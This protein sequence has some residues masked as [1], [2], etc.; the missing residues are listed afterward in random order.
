MIGPEATKSAAST[1]NRKKEALMIARESTATEIRIIQ[2]S[3]DSTETLLD[4]LVREAKEYAIFQVDP[5]G[6]ILNW[7]LGAE[8]MKQFTAEEAIGQNYRMLYRDED[9][10]SG[11]PERN[12]ALAIELGRHEEQWW[13]RKKDGTLFWADAVMTPIYSSD[14]ELLTFSKIVRDLTEGKRTE[15]ALRAA[16][17]AVEAASGLKSTFIAHMNHEIRTPLGAILG[18][19]EVLKDPAC[20]PKDRLISADVIDRNGK[21]LLRLIEDV[22]DISKIET[23]KLDIEISQFSLKILLHEIVDYFKTRASAKGLLLKIKNNNNIPDKITSDPARLRQILCNIIGNSVKFT[24]KGEVTIDV[25]RIDL[26]EGLTGIEF[27]VADTGAGLNGEERKALFKPFAQADSAINR[28][29]GGTGLGLALSRRLAEKLGGDLALSDFI[30][31]GGCSFRITIA[32]MDA[33]YLKEA[34]GA[35]SIAL[36]KKASSCNNSTVAGTKILVVDD[37]ADNRLLLKMLLDKRGVI[38]EFSKNGVEAVEKASLFNY[39]LIL[40]DIQMPIMDGNEAMR[41]LRRSGYTFPIVAV[42]AHS[43][44]EEKAKS[45][46][47]GCDDFLIKPINTKRLFEIVETYKH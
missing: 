30:Q 11:L 25:H 26:R 45:F 37:S 34:E 42:T 27:V 29:F 24:E 17:E 46:D 32:D 2:Q 16:N 20:S 3:H 18:F 13:R 12:I 44:N 6:L 35:I 47:A 23:G 7:N 22:L 1:C 19:S 28:K 8:R 31:G 4:L 39:D 36:D 43:M 38:V 10:K 5:E 40:M 33:A 9:Q 14:G 15:N 21:T 41:T